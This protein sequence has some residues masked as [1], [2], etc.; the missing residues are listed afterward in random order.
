VEV[1]AAIRSAN[2]LIAVRILTVKM[3]WYATQCQEPV[4][5]VT[6]ALIVSLVLVV[7]APV[8]TVCVITQ[9]AAQTKTVNLD[10]YVTPIPRCVLSGRAA[11]VPTQIVITG[12]T[13]VTLTAM[14]TAGTAIPLLGPADW[15]VAWMKTAPVCTPRPVTKLHTHVAAGTTTTVKEVLEIMY[16]T[17]QQTLVCDLSCM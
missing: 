8:K 2:I 17:C 12:T 16:V 6:L 3:T 14:R 5:S 13:C 11:T 15:A 4:L 7:V 9:S 1:I 10:M